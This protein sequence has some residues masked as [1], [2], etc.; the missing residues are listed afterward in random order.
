MIRFR[1]R[2]AYRAGR[3]RHGRRRLLTRATPGCGR[4]TW[5]WG[6]GRPRPG[7]GLAATSPPQS[8]AAA[9]EPPAPA[10][11]EGTIW[12]ANRGAD[13][14]RGSTQRPAR[15]STAWRCA[16]AHSRATSPTR[17]ASSTSRRSSAGRRPSPSS[18]PRPERSR[19]RS[20]TAPG[21]GHTTCTRVRTGLVAVGLYAT[22]TVAVVDTPTGALLGPWDTD[23]T[24]GEPPRP[25]WRLLARRADAVRRQRRHE[26]GD[27][28]RSTAVRCTGGWLC[29]AHTSSPS[30]RDGET[31]TSPAARRTR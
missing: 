10:T 1:V 6:S 26:R 29:R 17:E 15:S 13:T 11:V 9:A 16:P 7:A 5:R 28:A 31:P 14:I 25:C 2:E 18:T 22:D 30:A 27:R 4:R 23:P 20:L 21:R 24:R 3:H 8:S 12:V 19:G